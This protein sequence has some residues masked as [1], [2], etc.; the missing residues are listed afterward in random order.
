MVCIVLQHNIMNRSSVIYN[1]GNSFKES[2]GSHKEDITFLYLYLR[3]E[4]A[5]ERHYN[6]NKDSI[7]A[8]KKVRMDIR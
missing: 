3:I 2:T 6:V 5:L 7:F 4:K 1:L 8:H